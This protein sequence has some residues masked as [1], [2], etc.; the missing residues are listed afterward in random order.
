MHETTTHT[1]LVSLA[2][3]CG[4]TMVFDSPAPYVWDGHVVRMGAV[5]TLP[6]MSVA[7]AAHELAHFLCATEEE[8]LQPEW[9]LGREGTY[10]QMS[11]DPSHGAWEG[12]AGSCLEDAVCAA[13]VLLCK[14]LGV[15][16]PAGAADIARSLD[17]TRAGLARGDELEPEELLSL[18]RHRLALERLSSA[19]QA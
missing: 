12:F 5:G 10:G 8:R 18:E 6:A 1:A 4:L 14:M 15:V 19:T 16:P 2:Q 7:V 9:S 17:R 13:Q 11:T 3:T